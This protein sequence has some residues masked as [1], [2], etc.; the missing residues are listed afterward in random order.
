MQEE[1]QTA[2]DKAAVVLQ[3]SNKHI[4]GS[5]AAMATECAQSKRH[6]L[7]CLH[8]LAEACAREQEAVFAAVLE[9][10]SARATSHSGLRPAL[11]LEHVRHDETQTVLVARYLGN[12]P[13]SHRGKVGA[14]HTEM[15]DRV[16]TR[17]R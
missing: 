9:Y 16:A 1:G 7:R 8:A 5:V 14:R 11:L 4:Y 2:M 6:T 17:R 13:V 12:E 3:K 10:A 15:L